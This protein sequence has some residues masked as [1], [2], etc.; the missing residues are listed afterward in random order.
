MFDSLCQPMLDP[1]LE[2]L[3]DGADST[4]PQAKPRMELAVIACSEGTDRGKGATTR[5][6]NGR[7]G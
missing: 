3:Y 1:L 7:R 2:C 6:V 5:L 4:R